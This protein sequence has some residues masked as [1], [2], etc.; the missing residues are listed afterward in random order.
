MLTQIVA[1]VLQS[2]AG[3]GLGVLVNEIN[4]AV[5]A[6]L[7]RAYSHPLA[8][9]LLKL[10]P[11]ALVAIA[12]GTVVDSFAQEWQTTIPG[13]FFVTLYF[14]LQSSLMACAAAVQLPVGCHCDAW[15]TL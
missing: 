14:G 2:L 7:P 1:V 4:K 5:D 12:V 10:L 15:H 8:G 9:V 11:I 3:I 13:L 6:R